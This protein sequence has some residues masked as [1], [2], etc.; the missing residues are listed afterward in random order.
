[1]QPRDDSL[2][3]PLTYEAVVYLMQFL[4]LGELA[5]MK[6]TCRVTYREAIPFFH[7]KLMEFIDRIPKVCYRLCKA[8]A[9]QVQPSLKFWNLQCNLVWY[10]PKFTAYSGDRVE[11]KKKKMK[12]HSDCLTCGDVAIRS[13]DQQSWR[14]KPMINMPVQN[15]KVYIQ[16]ALTYSIRTIFDERDYTNKGKLCTRI[17]GF[18]CELMGERWMTAHMPVLEEQLTWEVRDYQ[19]DENEKQ[20]YNELI[21]LTVHATTVMSQGTKRKVRS[22]SIGFSA[23]DAKERRDPLSK[24]L[25]LF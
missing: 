12:G 7:Q 13:I 20:L 17:W 22:A 21:D 2:P 18:F 25:R 3:V 15:I 8:D 19:K 6:M 1:M 23:F 24:R 16:K 4:D 11:E 10:V 14:V 5:R 9:Q